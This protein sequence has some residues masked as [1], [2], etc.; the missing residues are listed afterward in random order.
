MTRVYGEP[1][2]GDRFTD[3]RR[4][5]IGGSDTG[6]ILGVGF[7]SALEVW[8]QK[9]GIATRE[10]EPSERMVW[11]T[12]LEGAIL[13]GYQQDFGVTI[14]RQGF[15]RHPT[16][17]FV[18]GHV[19]AL[20]RDRLV[21]VKT[22]AVLDSRWG[23]DGSADVP[24]GYFAQVQHYLILTGMPV[25]DLIV[26]VS[27][28]ELHRYVIPADA[29][30]QEALLVEEAAFWRLVEDGTPPDPDGSESAGRALRAL[31]PRAIPD[32]VIATPEVNGYADSYIAAK[33]RRDAYAVDVERYAQ[34]MQSFMG[35]RERLIGVGYSALWGNRQGA[36]SWKGVAGDL[37]TT[38]GLI[39][40]ID[41]ERSMLPTSDALASAIATARESIEGYDALIESHRGEP[42]RAFTFTRRKGE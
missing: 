8:E 27:G 37:H 36:V 42:T 22:T 38:L 21:E 31:F 1:L 3:Q 41:S 10:R 24:P 14:R 6:S 19:D 13:E 32:E 30:F 25:A 18:I 35:A 23:E 4:S 16:Y 9:R 26:L 20:A 29:T 17:P 40:S 34:L 12:R 15:R 39:A 2:S 33:E 11:G 28:R 5:G 7:G